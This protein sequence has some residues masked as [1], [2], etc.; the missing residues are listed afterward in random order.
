[1]S[2]GDI[3]NKMVMDDV[4]TN[5]VYFASTT[6]HQYMTIASDFANNTDYAC[7]KNLCLYD[8]TNPLGVIAINCMPP[9]CFKGTNHFYASK[10][11]FDINHFLNGRHY[12]MPFANI[13]LGTCDMGEAFLKCLTGDCGGFIITPNTPTPNTTTPISQIPIRG[14]GPNNDPASTAIVHFPGTPT[15]AP[16]SPSGDGNQINPNLSP[17]NAGNLRSGNPGAQNPPSNQQSG[18][19]AVS[20]QQSS[21]TAQITSTYDPPNQQPTSH[22]TTTSNS[23]TSTLPWFILTLLN[24]L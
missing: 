11:P 23:V 9:Y 6:Q 16:V 19:T 5:D 21:S 1:M 14:P 15:N 18:S 8:I 24:L 7:G 10:I 4:N 22:P 17:G 3:C 13:T 2:P 12:V 20:N